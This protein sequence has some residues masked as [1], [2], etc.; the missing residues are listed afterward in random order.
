MGIGLYYYLPQ[1]VWSGFGLSSAMM[2][3]ASLL[4]FKFRNQEKE[5][6]IE[7]KFTWLLLICMGVGILLIFAYKSMGASNFYVGIGGGITFVSAITYCLELVIRFVDGI[8]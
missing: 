5:K 2:C 8:R 3:F 7:S 4:H 6:S 1:T